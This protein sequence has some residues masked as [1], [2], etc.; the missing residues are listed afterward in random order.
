M[1]MN[2]SAIL[3]KVKTKGWCDT[4][5]Q[6][7]IL[8]EAGKDISYLPKHKDKKDKE[9]PNS[10]YSPQKNEYFVTTSEEAIAVAKFIE[11]DEGG[12]LNGDSLHSL[13]CGD[14]DDCDDTRLLLAKALAKY[15][16]QQFE[17]DTK[18]KD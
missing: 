16:L 1:T 3:A 17:I 11:N 8:K 7:L 2:Q 18:K 5:K 15:F 14:G 4:C 13:A 10:H 6:W 9:C 12:C